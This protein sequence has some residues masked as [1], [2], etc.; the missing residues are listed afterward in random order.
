MPQHD[1]LASTLLATTSFVVLGLFLFGLAFWVIVK[2]TPF[3]IRKE[4]EDDQN[5]SL[6]ILIASVFLGIAIIIGSA[7]HG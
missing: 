5:T 7:I 2:I 3:S 1:S 6:A 4:I